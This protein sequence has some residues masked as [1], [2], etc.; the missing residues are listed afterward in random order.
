MAMFQRRAMGE[1]L[2]RPL[3]NA[4]AS[5]RVGVVK[6][7]L[8]VAARWLSRAGILVVREAQLLS[9]QIL[10]GGVGFIIGRLFFE[11]LT[12][13]LAVAFMAGGLGPCGWLFLRAQKREQQA[14]SLLPD[15]LELLSVGMEAGLDFSAALK[16]YVQKGP[17]GLMRDEFSRVLQDI[18]TGKTRQ[19]AMQGLMERLPFEFMASPMSTILQGLKLGAGITALLKSQAEHLR[20]VGWEAVQKKAQEAPVKLLFPLLIFIFP[21]IFIVLFGPFVISLSKSGF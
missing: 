17:E 19:Q 21:T 2:L 3:E 10:M 13:A 7:Y 12:G 20:N 4:I 18:S 14:L 15:A 11:S 1:A 6:A 8:P 5:C 16:I 9:A